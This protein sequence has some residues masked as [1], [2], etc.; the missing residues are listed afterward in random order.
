MAMDGS[1][2]INPTGPQPE[3]GTGSFGGGDWIGALI[4]VVGSMINNNQAKQA[5][6]R[7][8]NWNKDAANL[9]YE[10]DKEMWNLQNQ[11]N[12]PLEQRKRWAEAGMNPN[13][14]YGG[15]TGGN[16]SSMTHMSAPSAV[17][18]PGLMPNLPGIINMFQDMQLKHA[19]IDNVKAQTDSTLQNTVNN[20]V[21][22]TIL[23]T[24]SGREKLAFQNEQEYS[25]E[26]M[27]QRNINQ[28]REGR[29]L[30]QKWF[31]QETARDTELL[32][33]KQ[34]NANLGS[35]QFEN[36]KRQQDIIFKKH[37]NEFRQIGLTD[38]DNVWM[39]LIVRTLMNQNM[40]PR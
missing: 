18:V 7:Q 5:A 30:G 35:I 28:M 4:G 1:S 27:K 40:L 26:W 13:L 11:Y 8:N 10:R 14:A 22:E 9:A 16:S 19:Q 38:S 12:S 6:E 32:R 25:S 37:Q 29:L 24:K 31:N 33:Q 36:E 3:G 2:G 17:Q 39:R 23:G 21:K 15:A 34:I 20:A